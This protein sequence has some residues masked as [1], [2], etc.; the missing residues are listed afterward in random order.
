VTAPEHRRDRLP[1][2]FVEQPGTD[3]GGNTLT[4][5]R[6]PMTA[7]LRLA[8]AP[9]PTR[10]SKSGPVQVQGA[11]PNLDGIGTVA[12]ASFGLSPALLPEPELKRER[13]MRL[14]KARARGLVQNNRAG[15]DTGGLGHS[16][17]R[18]CVRAQCNPFSP[19][20]YPPRNQASPRASDCPQ[21]ALLGEHPSEVL[22]AM[23]HNAEP[24]AAT[25]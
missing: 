2:A 7:T 11:A 23:Q 21:D 17:R 5:S 12:D 25:E 10:H 20:C 19:Q 1:F 15:G 18:V 24:G 8:V 9:P 6:C 13:R 16:L 14:A 4:D 22:G 3:Q